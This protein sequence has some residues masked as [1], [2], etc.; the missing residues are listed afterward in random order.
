MKLALPWTADCTSVFSLEITDESQIELAEEVAF[1]SDDCEEGIG[2]Q[3][4]TEPG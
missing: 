2:R 4:K 1:P 3:G